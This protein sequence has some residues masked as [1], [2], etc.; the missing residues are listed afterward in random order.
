M[1]NKTPPP[2]PPLNAP[3]LSSELPACSIDQVEGKSVN[4][5]LSGAT[6][7]RRPAAAAVACAPA[8]IEATPILGPSQNSTH[9]AIGKGSCASIYASND[10]VALE[11][12]SGDDDNNGNEYLSLA[13]WLT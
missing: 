10:A 4:L 6:S 7:T 12:D 13:S 1:S 3:H 11:A 9:Q 5:P 2:L 8:T